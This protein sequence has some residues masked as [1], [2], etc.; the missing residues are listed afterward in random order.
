MATT[1]DVIGTISVRIN[2]ITSDLDKGL[3]RG[4][5]RLAAFSKKATQMGRTLTRRV[6]LPLTLAGVAATKMAVTFDEEMT[7][8]ITLV[9]VADDQVN[10]W[11]Q[12]ILALG[13]AVGI[14][15]TE[16]A[17]ALFVVTS[18]GERGANALDIVEQ[19]AKASAIGLG[20]TAT[21]ARAVTA[22]MQAYSKQG[23]TAS[24]ATEIL[25]AT[26]REGNLEA[27]SLAGSLGRVIGIA[28]Q[29]G[30]SFEQVGG[31][32]ATFTRLGVSAEESTTALR[33][34]LTLLLKP[35]KQS[36]QALKS[37]GLSAEA[38][39][40][41]VGE[42][43]LA[44]TLR[45]LVDRF[46]GQEEILAQVIPNVRALSGVLGTAGSQGEAFAQINENIANSLGIVDEGFNRVR[47]TPA[48][49][50][51]EFTA[52]AAVM[53]IE[54]GNK[55]IPTFKKVVE[56]ASELIDKFTSLDS[57]TQDNI[58]QFGILAATLGPVLLIIGSMGT[59]LGKIIV[60]LRAMPKHLTAMNAGWVI[61]LATFIKI[62]QAM[63]DMFKA[64]LDLIDVQL[65]E[66]GRMAAAIQTWLDRIN[67]LKRANFEAFKQWQEKLQEVRERGITGINAFIVA[68]SELRRA[69]IL[70][71]QDIGD[72]AANFNDE[73]ADT[74]VEIDKVASRAEQ[75]GK[76]ITDSLVNNMAAFAVMTKTAS[77]AFSSFIDVVLRELSRLLARA[78]LAAIATAIFGPAAGAFVLGTPVPR[79]AG[80]PLRAGQPAI[81][82][83]MGPELFVPQQAGTVV[84]NHEMN[85]T[86]NLNV[87]VSTLGYTRGEEDVLGR[88]LKTIIERA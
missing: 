68:W 5:R 38:L 45:L 2:A 66:A 19:A 81:V 71:F 65:T 54:I 80:G 32:I 52:S 20:D 34:I 74:V 69:G 36:E 88:R 44:G 84:S 86:V 59:G 78:G 3:K 14:G 82:G 77:D 49:E 37:A 4:E 42:Q 53:A 28:S 67:E 87:T 63:E 39:R 75:A 76:T 61:V 57:K 1:K 29:V 18:A 46:K 26:V 62:V 51:K 11:R 47:Q 30:V 15:P 6:T 27:A 48:Q 83:E 40:R 16:L 73:L 58:I 9:G 10:E 56:F 17:R 72:A 55:L 8:I 64:Q 43:G 31:F 70:A 22:A 50:W 60:W 24:R 25:V 12:S 23:L 79:A 41:S 33:Q 21:T 7:K 13:P 85:K 35:T